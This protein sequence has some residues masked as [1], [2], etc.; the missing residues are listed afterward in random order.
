MS[1]PLPI[2]GL[3]PVR[4][5]AWC[6]RASIE[7]SLKWCSHLV[8]LDH[9]STDATDDILD[10]A[11]DDRVHVVYENDPAW[12][13]ANIRQRLLDVGR[14]MGNDYYALIDA[15][16][17]LTRDTMTLL[18]GFALMPGELIRMP[19]RNMWR[20]LEWYRSDNS[21]FGSQ[22][23]TDVVFRDAPGISFQPKEGG[24]Q[25]HTRRPV[26]CHVVEVG[27]PG[28]LHIQH[29][30]WR[31]LCAKQAL[32]KM[33]EVLVYG[34][35]VEEINARYDPT[36]SEAGL[37]TKLLLA[38]WRPEV[39]DYVDLAAAPWQEAECHRLWNRHGS[40][41]FKGLNLYGVCDGI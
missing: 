7:W 20:S 14:R 38:D 22:S 9:N 8:V 12:N 6:L 36:V 25:I 2:T 21:R 27:G 5:E 3:M 34:K 11:W 15:D 37:E 24:Y 19:W 17:F 18:Q 28:V 30:N 31:R 32:Y 16:E 33:N 29:A 13:E 40:A 41:R 23:M 35:P 10:S 4:N 1:N 39:W 26:G